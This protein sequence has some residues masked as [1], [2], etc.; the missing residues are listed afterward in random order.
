MQCKNKTARQTPFT[1]N[2][3]RPPKKDHFLNPFWKPLDG[4]F[5]QAG[6]RPQM[7][8]Q[9][10]DTR[11]LGF[12]TFFPNLRPH[13][14]RGKRPG[15]TAICPMPKMIG[16]FAFPRFACQKWVTTCHNVLRIF[17]E[18]MCVIGMSFM[19]TAKFCDIIHARRIVSENLEK[20]KHSPNI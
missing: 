20:T 14:G 18:N 1:E 8:P 10:G 7:P 2:M 3:Y 13:C 5:S 4:L 17:C 15:Q 6:K 9:K 11:L 19:R 12:T 16:N